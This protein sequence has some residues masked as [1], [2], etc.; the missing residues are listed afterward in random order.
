MTDAEIDAWIDASAALLGIPV[1]PEWHAAIRQHL[2]ITLGHANT[3]MAFK[4]P[5]DAEPAAVFHA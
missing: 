1:R 3:V 4:L 2:T 5:D